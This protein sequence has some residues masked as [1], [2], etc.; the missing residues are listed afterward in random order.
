MIHHFVAGAVRVSLRTLWSPIYLIWLRLRVAVWGS[1]AFEHAVA[2]CP[3]WLALEILKAYGT[4]I[5]PGI[6][7]HGRLNLHGAYHVKGKLTIGRQ[8]H[9]GPNVTLDLTGPIVLEDCCTISLNTQI[10]THQDV[11]YSPLAAQLFPTET[12]NVTVEAGAYIGAGAIILSNVRVGRCS[13]V[14]AGA[15]VNR[16][17]P[18]FTVVAG[19]PAKVIKQ[20]DRAQV[21]SVH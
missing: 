21:E 11:G 18:P 6:D 15:V 20:L 19:V 5:G 12:G 13:V 10:L 3:P 4:V 9:I 1:A 16:D 2:H 8:V 14:A 17:V 7:F